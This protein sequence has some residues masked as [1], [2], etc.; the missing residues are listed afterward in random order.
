MDGNS[1]HTF[2]ARTG[3]AQTGWTKATHSGVYTCAQVSL[4]ELGNPWVVFMGTDVEGGGRLMDQTGWQLVTIPT[5][6]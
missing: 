6:P 5:L 3:A 1:V 2:Q 4:S